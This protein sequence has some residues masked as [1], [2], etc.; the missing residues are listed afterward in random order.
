LLERSSIAVDLDGTLLRS[1]RTVGHINAAALHGAHAAGLTIVLATSRGPGGLRRILA[2][3]DFGV[4]AATY[5][6]ALLLDATD[7]KQPRQAAPDHRLD[8]VDAEALLRAGER[9]G[10]S[11][12]WYVHDSWY[13]KRIDATVDRQATI[14]GET[15][16]VVAA[17]D[18]LPAPHKVMAIGRTRQHEQAL[19]R[20]A[21][22]LPDGM[23]KQHTRDDYLEVISANVRSAQFLACASR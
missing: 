2:E 7:P 12:H 23:D 14:T 9:A 3:L 20:L 1:D 5:G 8:P 6:G 18:H 10:A 16:D 4:L 19:R 22:R 21:C 13:V 17:F 11:T 15:P